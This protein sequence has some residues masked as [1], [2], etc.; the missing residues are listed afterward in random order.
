MSPPENLGGRLTAQH[1]G[2]RYVDDCRENADTWTDF[3][4]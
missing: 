3:A 1:P 4:K 2:C